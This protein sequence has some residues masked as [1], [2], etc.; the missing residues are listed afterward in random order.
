[1]SLKHGVFCFVVQLT[2]WKRV[3]PAEDISFCHSSSKIHLMHLMP[4]IAACQESAADKLRA[5]S[6]YNLHERNTAAEDMHTQGF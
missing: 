1:M 2:P 6:A 4:R 3:V 5:Q